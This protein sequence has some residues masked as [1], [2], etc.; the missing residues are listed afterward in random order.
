VEYIKLLNHEDSLTADWTPNVLFYICV[1]DGLKQMS[2]WDM[3][4]STWPCSFEV[5]WKSVSCYQSL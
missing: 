4:L 2:S 5:L 3:S 1:S